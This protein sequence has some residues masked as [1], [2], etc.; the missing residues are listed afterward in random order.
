MFPEGQTH[1]GAGSQRHPNFWNP[2][3]CPHISTN[4]DQIPWVRSVFLEFQPPLNYGVRCGVPASQTFLDLLHA[5][6]QHDTQQPILQGDQTRWEEKFYRVDHA[7]ALVIILVT[8]MLMRDLFAVANLVVL[9]VPC[10][11]ISIVAINIYLQI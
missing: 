4:T 11:T 6:T 1:K 9:I 2:Y 10:V 8:R 3:L 7:P 5:R